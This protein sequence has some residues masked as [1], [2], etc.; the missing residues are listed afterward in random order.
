VAAGRWIVSA[1]LAGRGVLIPRTTDDFASTIVRYGVG[2][3]YRLIPRAPVPVT[4]VVELVGWLL[5][6]GFAAA[7]LTG[8]AAEGHLRFEDASADPIVNLKIGVRLDAG[9]SGSS[10]LQNCPWERTN[11][12]A[13]VTELSLRLHPL[14]GRPMRTEPDARF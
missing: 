12:G 9:Q 7:S 6:G 5:S 10:Q 8:R 4:P 13:L 2:L 3:S 11:G 14:G 1:R